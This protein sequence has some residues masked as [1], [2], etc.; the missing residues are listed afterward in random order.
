M[1]SWRSSLVVVGGF[2]GADRSAVGGHGY[3]GAARPAV[4]APHGSQYGA[5][6]AVASRVINN[7]CREGERALILNSLNMNE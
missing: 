6:R 1:A 5:D 4:G 3:G 7:N 2:G